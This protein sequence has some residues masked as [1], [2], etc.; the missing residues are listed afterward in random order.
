MTT[1][2]ETLGVG[3]GA[4]A[5]E[6][7]QAY[8]RAAKDA[9]PDRGGSA[10]EFVRVQAAF[11]TLSD[12]KRRA[13]YDRAQ[14]QSAAD[15]APGASEAPQAPSWGETTEAPV[16]EPS[17]EP[18]TEPAPRRADPSGRFGRLRQRPEGAAARPPMFVRSKDIDAKVVLRR[19]RFFILASFLLMGYAHDFL[20]ENG[21]M[22]GLADAIFG[23]IGLVLGSIIALMLTWWKPRN[24]FI[25]LLGAVL[26]AVELLAAFQ[27]L[28]RWTSES[29]G[30][31]AL[32][33]GTFF[34]FAALA[35]PSLALWRA[36]RRATRAAL[37]GKDNLLVREWT[38]LRF[39]P[40]QL[41][42]VEEQRLDGARPYV[43]LRD[44]VARG[45]YGGEVNKRLSVGT[46]VK[47]NVEGRQI[48][49]VTTDSHSDLERR[50]WEYL[51]S[52]WLEKKVRDALGR[53]P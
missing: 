39:A 34:L 35:Y 30:K 5:D 47:A 36:D 42:W 38:R 23:A 20:W 12:A 8:R 45:R 4:S 1:H 41:L 29:P 7:R 37:I 3:E 19:R 52:G 10:E 21:I 26:A 44:P 43:V 33:L 17:T 9:H 25:G 28:V 6:V 46:W 22:Y 40:G 51:T 16:A 50:T 2:Y 53:R 18:V 13:A 14:R 31:A 32:H 11:D 15:P 24:R 49:S 27:T 48:R